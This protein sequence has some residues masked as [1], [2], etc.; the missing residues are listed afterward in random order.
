[1][2]N[3]R[4]VTP[5][6]ER[7]ASPAVADKI[8]AA[9]RGRVP[10]SEVP[11]LVQATYLRALIAPRPPETLNELVRLV[12][13]IAR[14]V[15]VDFHRKRA[16][17]ARRTVD[18]EDPDRVAVE[19]A[20]SSARDPLEA[21]EVLDWIDREVQRG[22]LPEEALRWSRELAAGATCQEIARREGKSVSAVKVAI[23]R[24]RKLVHERWR[25]YLATA[26]LGALALFAIYVLRRPRTEAIVRDTAPAP[27][28]APT[29]A[30]PTRLQ[31]AQEFRDQAF[32]ACADS[33]WL[34]CLRDFNEAKDRDPAGDADPRVQA[35][36]KKA[37]EELRKAYDHPDKK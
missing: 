18:G 4:S 28:L 25:A 7:L 29:P 3:S 2:L 12:S 26:A 5:H 15:V 19:D 21:R 34:E 14:N 33:R 10:A 36:R 22:Q 11:D 35:V 17:H 6:A 13:V 20:P 37:G 9:I 32:R 30:A 1:M 8:L 24:A 31:Q 23:H 27:A 16:H